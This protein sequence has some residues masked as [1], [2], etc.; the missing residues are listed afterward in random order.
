MNWLLSILIGL[1]AA[2]LGCF[3]AGV[4]AGFCV[5]WYRISSF[6]GASGYFVVFMA[7][8]GAFGGLLLGIVCSRVAA[9]WQRPN[10]LKGLGFALGS[11]AGIVLIVGVICR[12]AADLAPQID[13]RDL[14]LAI[15]VRGPESFVIPEATEPYKP[16]A[17]VI[18][19]KSRAQPTGELRLNEAKQ[20]EGRWIVAATVP[21][22]TSSSQKFLRV[23]FNEQYNELFPLPLSSHPSRQ[24]L[25]WSRWVEA[26]WPVDKAKPPPEASFTMRYRVELVEPTPPGPTQEEIAAQAAA[27]DEA[28]FRAIRA[29]APIEQWLP[30]TRYGTPEARLQTAIL[31]ITSRKDFVEELSALMRSKEPEIRVD[32]LRV[33]EHVD[34][35]PAA[36]ATPVA[37]VGRQIAESI[38][39]F[40]ATT[41]EQD[42]TYQGAAAVA[43]E[44]SAWMVAVRALQGKDGVGSHARARRHSRARPRASRQHRDAP[45]RRAR[46]ELLSAR[47]GGDR[48]AAD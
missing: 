32:A 31:H 44:F 25:E 37:E 47:V 6:E 16:S 48:A 3:G 26:G 34:P 21:L 11:T 13:G 23:Y 46:G 12:L 2:A 17:E 19:L 45:G 4:V 42:P 18:V 22:E 15:E 7:L 1:L 41:P 5:G 27:E 39:A 33:L 40:N 20:V 14:E 9:R 29:D 30:Y 8:I 10:V 28:K 38:R 24:D 43:V 36:L 35:P